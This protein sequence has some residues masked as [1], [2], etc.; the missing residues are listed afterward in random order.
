MARRPVSILDFYSPELPVAT[1][2]RRLLQRIQSFSTESEN[3]AIMITSAMLAEGKSTICSFLA[4]TAARQKGLKTLIIDT[5]LRRPSIHKLFGMDRE[6]GLAEVLSGDLSAAKVVRQT[7]LEQL[8]I[9]NAGLR[10]ER[11]SELFNVEVISRII[12]DLKF[13]YDLI[14][15]D[16]APILP[17]SDPMLLAPKMDAIL[18]VVKAGATQKEVVERAVDILGA[19][20]N[21]ITGVVLN[22]MNNSLPYYYDYKYYDYD[23]PVDS[24]KHRRGDRR[25]KRQSRSRSSRQTASRLTSK[26]NDTPKRFP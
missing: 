12:D 4:L 16:C 17:V 1:E 24:A 26:N 18:L 25:R 6:R 7:D 8:H 20:G 23:S 3:K 19:D 5:D 2:F 10:S 21:R 9:I 11:P 13:Y 15:V 14:F 22:N